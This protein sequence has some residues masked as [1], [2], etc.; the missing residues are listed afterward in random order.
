MPSI[1]ESLIGRAGEEDIEWKRKSRNH[2]NKIGNQWPV[3][4]FFLLVV[5]NAVIGNQ[6]SSWAAAVEIVWGICFARSGDRRTISPLAADDAN[7][8]GLEAATLSR[9]STDRKEMRFSSSS[10]F[11]LLQLTKKTKK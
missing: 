3:G 4:F 1:E 11:F 10:L 2:H 7:S 5:V 8:V 6:G 9:D